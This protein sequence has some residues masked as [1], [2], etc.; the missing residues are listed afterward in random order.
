MIHGPAGTLWA[1]QAS[2]AL[3]RT[4]A[5]RFGTPSHLARRHAEQRASEVCRGFK[6]LG[7]VEARAGIEPTYK[8]LQYW[9]ASF[10][11]LP[12]GP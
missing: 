5:L 6:I 9:L 2:K 10:P 1:K 3:R 8:A 12:F 7:T 4:R 11:T